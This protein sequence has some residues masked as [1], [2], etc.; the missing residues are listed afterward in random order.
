MH[1]EEI[2]NV[3]F[4]PNATRMINSRRMSMQHA[5]GRLRRRKHREFWWESWKERDQ[6]EDLDIGG[7]IIL[8]WMLDM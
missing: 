4:W 6:Y 2:Q 8:K 1:N 5:W 3:H 7:R